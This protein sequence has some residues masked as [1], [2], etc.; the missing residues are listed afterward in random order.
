MSP[1]FINTKLDLQTRLADVARL[2]VQSIV[3]YNIAI[4]SL[5]RAKGTLLRYD[6]IVLEEEPKP[7]MPNKPFSSSRR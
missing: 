6:N 7:F 4:S 2:E 1:A 3:N 5:E